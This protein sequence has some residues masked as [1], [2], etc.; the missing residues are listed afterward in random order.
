MATVASL[1]G[2]LTTAMLLVRGRFASKM[3]V[4]IGEEEAITG[5]LEILTEAWKKIRG[6][7]HEEGI[8]LAN[9]PEDL[10]DPGDEPAE[11]AAGLVIF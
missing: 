8:T 5:D 4:R 6:E 10:G 9:V 7:I 3:G 1:I 2:R 11:I